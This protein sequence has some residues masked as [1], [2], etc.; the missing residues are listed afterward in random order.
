MA[1][2][3]DRDKEL[4]HVPEVSETTLSPPQSPG[5]LE[6]KLSAPGSNGFVGYS[7]APLSRKV[8]HIAKAQREPMVQ[9]HGMADNLGWKAVAAVQ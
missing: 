9:P 4:V 3:A 7:D 8:F 5:V 6:S 1:L 2:A